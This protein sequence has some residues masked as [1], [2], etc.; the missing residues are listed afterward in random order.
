MT[1]AQL[2]LE[3]LDK[4]KHAARSDIFLCY[5]QEARPPLYDA[6]E[7]EIAHYRQQIEN[8]NP[9][10]AAMTDIQKRAQE[11]GIKLDTTIE[12]NIWRYGE[13]SAQKH[14]ESIQNWLEEHNLTDATLVM[15]RDEDGDPFCSLSAQVTESDT[16]L[17]M[18]ID[19]RE[20]ALKAAQDR[21]R[22]EYERLR[23]KFE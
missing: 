11:L 2:A 15:G 8:L 22:A 3:L 21:E 10:G 20:R 14:I 6:L 1:L 19:C 4:Y 12:H 9:S 16:E 7:E 23:K 18:V 13:S 5:K 17:A